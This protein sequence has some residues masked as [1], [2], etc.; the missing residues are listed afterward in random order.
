MEV[1]PDLNLNWLLKDG[2]LNMF[3]GVKQDNSPVLPQ[4]VAKYQKKIGNEDLYDKLDEI[5]TE[6]KKVTVKA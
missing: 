2:D 5:L 4:P 1:F 3:I 6:I